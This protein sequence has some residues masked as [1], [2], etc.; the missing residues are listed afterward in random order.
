[1]PVQQTQVSVLNSAFQHMLN[2]HAISSPS[3]VLKISVYWITT[4]KLRILVHINT[5]SLEAVRNFCPFSPLGTQSLLICFFTETLGS[6][7]VPGTLYC[8][9]LAHTVL[10]SVTSFR[11][12]ILWLFLLNES[13]AGPWGKWYANPCLKEASVSCCD[14]DTAIVSQ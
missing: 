14:T 10:L 11:E 5:L 6:G 12:N 1:M 13:A 7:I 8:L 9:Y 2:F 4:D 3:D